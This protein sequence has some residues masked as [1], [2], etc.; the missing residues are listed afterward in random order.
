MGYECY[1]C[2]GRPRWH[3]DKYAKEANLG[4]YLISTTGGEIF[5]K[6]TNKVLYQQRIDTAS[7]LKLLKLAK[8]Y[9]I[10]TSFQSGYNIYTNKWSCTDHSYRQLIVNDAKDL[11][12]KTPITQVL[13]KDK[14]VEKIKKVKE[15]ILLMKDVKIIN[16][17][18][19]LV[20]ADR[21]YNPEKDT[22]YLDISAPDTSKGNAVKFLCKHLN[23][24][25]DDIICIGDSLNDISMLEIA[26]VAVAMENASHDVKEIADIIT[27]SN[28]DNGVAKFIK[29]HLL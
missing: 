25:L 1:I 4:R 11:F 24:S 29:N 26:G 19:H 6:L 9:D 27:S 14:D 8:K 13:F 17:L 18:K 10:E 7:L 20:Y 12:D 3:A 16:Q 28:E 22:A 2:T 5:D 23:I 21:P 15:E